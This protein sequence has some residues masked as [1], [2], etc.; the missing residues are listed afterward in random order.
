MDFSDLWWA[1][2]PEKT[3][4]LFRGNLSRGQTGLSIAF[5]LPTQCGYSSDHEVAQPEIGKVECRSIV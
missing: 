1:Y 5:D 3:N 2:K 4:E